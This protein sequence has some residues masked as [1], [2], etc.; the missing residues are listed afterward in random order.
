M[1]SICLYFQ[2]HQ[3]FRLRTYRFFD[4]GADHYYYDDYQ[5]KR[6][7]RRIATDCYLPA[8]EVLLG[9]INEFGSAFKVT[10]SI[11]GTALDQFK[12]YAPEVIESFKRLAKT[13]N[14]EFL[15]ETFSHSLVG[16]NDPAEFKRQVKEHDAAIKEL[17]GVIPTA[18][19]NTELVYSNSIAG[20]VLEMGYKTMLTEGAKQLLGWKSPN[21]LYC[22]APHQRLKLLLRNYQ[23]S[24]DIAFRFSQQS[25]SEWP[26]TAEKYVTWI[27]NVDPKQELVNLFMDYE[28]FGEH[29]K[30]ESGIFGFLRA[31]PE[32]L[33]KT[34]KW[35]FHTPSEISD[36]LQPVAGIDCPHAISWADEERDLT[37]WLGNDLQNEAYSSLC[38]V[39]DTMSAC[40][41]QDLHR[42]WDYLQTSDHFYYMCTK[43]FSDGDV[44]QYFNPYGSPYD[45]F[46]NYMNILS[47]FLIRVNEYTERA[48]TVIKNSTVEDVI[49]GKKQV[50]VKA[51]GQAIKK[52]EPKAETIA[53]TAKKAT[54]KPGKK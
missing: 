52:T 37:A 46:L 25:W 14:V 6:I 54:A 7:V 4:I 48:P 8:N 20:L 43:W 19:R 2:V 26:L 1:R 41:D 40:K 17:F 23:L 15:A 49:P 3:P 35:V 51:K 16:L 32:Q 30:A 5:N 11:S 50:A 53:K 44:H 22:S 47:D 24:D 13:G 27:N 28:T 31:F 39:S 12:K 42:D 45:A 10:F 38:K 34:H 9:L 33:I 29:Q 21:Y 36:D 18:F